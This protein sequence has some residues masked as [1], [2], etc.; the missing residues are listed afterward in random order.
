MPAKPHDR[1]SAM[2]DQPAKKR[3]GKPRGTRAVPR[4]PTVPIDQSLLGPMMAALPNDRWRAA[5]VA[6]FMVKTNTAAA[7]LAGFGNELGTTTASNL[8]RIAYS[9]FHDER[10]LKALR[11]LGEKHLVNGIPDAIG[12]IEE[13]LADVKHKDRLRAAQTLIDRAYPLTAH[14]HLTIEHKINY[15]EQALEEL[16]AFRRLGVARAKLEEIYGADGLYHLEQQLDA[17]PKVIEGEFTAIADHTEA[18]AHE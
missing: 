7:K 11:E 14:Q 18:A 9:V 3:G 12:A 13:I 15:Q 2:S 6:R 4:K 17:K 16:A 8:K 10:M 1:F 5:A